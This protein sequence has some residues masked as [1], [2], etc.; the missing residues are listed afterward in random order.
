MAVEVKGILLS[1]LLNGMNYQETGEFVKDLVVRK[2]FPLIERFSPLAYSIANNIIHM[3][4]SATGCSLV[5]DLF[6]IVLA[7]PYFQENNYSL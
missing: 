2:Q 1:R 6:N 4:N 5:S 3:E 7:K